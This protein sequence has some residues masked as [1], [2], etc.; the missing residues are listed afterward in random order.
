MN[1]DDNTV[2]NSIK[3]LDCLKKV[4]VDESVASIECFRN[5]KM[6]ANPNKLQAI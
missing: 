2:S 6:Q 5:N 1:F 4:L 3:N